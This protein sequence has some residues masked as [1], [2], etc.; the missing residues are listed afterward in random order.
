MSIRE[1]IKEL[2]AIKYRLKQ[3]NKEANDLRKRSKVIEQSIA[4][5]LNARNLPGVKDDSGIAIV[6]EEKILR[7]HKRNK[8]RDNDALQIL[9]KYG[10]HSPEKVL[11]EVLDARKGE[12]KRG[13]KIKLSKYNANS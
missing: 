9:E 4:E 3:I 10:V 13:H 12:E 1:E 2:E 8:D 11:K 6:V 7:A 5:F